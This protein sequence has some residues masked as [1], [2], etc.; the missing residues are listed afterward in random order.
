M[1]GSQS[2]VQQ[3]QCAVEIY[4]FEGGVYAVQSGS[5]AG[6]GLLT[7]E[8]TKSIRG[9]TGS[10]RIVLTPG[11]PLGSN[12][13]TWAEIVTPQSLVLIGMQRNGGQIV[14][15]GVVVATDEVEAFSPNRSTMRETV[16]YGEDF[17]RYFAA[18]NYYTL[19]A[20]GIT[21]AAPLNQVAN[22][23]NTLPGANAAFPVQLNPAYYQGAPDE[24]GQA[25]YKN[26]MAGP[27]GMLANTYVPYKKGNIN[28]GDA[29]LASFQAFPTAAIPSAVDFISSEGTWEAKFRQMFPLPWYEFFAVTAPSGMYG[30]SSYAQPANPGPAVSG[31]AAATGTSF[32]KGYPF[33]M[34]TMPQL[35]PV[36]PQI[37]ARPNPLPVLTLNTAG[38]GN[39]SP[40]VT[41]INATAWNA[42]PL[43]DATNIG[44]I[45]TT[46]TFTA[47]ELKTFY[48]FT[49]TNLNS[50][51]GGS[52]SSN[53]TYF[54]NYVGAVDTAANARYGYRPLNA[55]SYWFADP[56][57]I[58]AQ[59]N[60]ANN[61]QT[62]NDATYSL[63]ANLVSFYHP[64][65][66]MARASVT[67]NLSPTINIGARFRF[68]PTKHTQ[69]WDFYV[70]QVTHVYAFGGPSTTK[71][72]LT[73][74]LPTEVYK[75]SGAS[76]LLQAIH[77]GA[78]QRY[79][80]VYVPVRQPAA[81]PGQTNTPPTAPVLGLQFYKG[82]D[83]PTMRKIVTQMANGFSVPQFVPEP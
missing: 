70:E 22:Q 3:P 6:G 79:Q 28:F 66:L 32:G 9:M 25:W 35:P 62:M 80:G 69:T 10:F 72:M 42:L 71:L 40:T 29:V 11:G 30:T 21:L 17:G 78:A 56:Q 63:I 43:I 65:A 37:I 38:G 45:D 68:T 4:P 13:P 64:A 20:L 14:M 57:G 55:T 50:L 33:S 44:P 2:G 75:D 23:G 8:V 18:Y 51:Q 24:I 53:T 47:E 7:C 49:P 77:R 52:N 58:A 61:G 41:G 12:G 48:S 34:T 39:V 54:Q 27:N 36:S 74:G 1:S 73:R 59:K 46:L 81:A 60:A 16:I 15:A 5:S 19:S 31:A 82:T 67:L 83:N 26:I 76:G